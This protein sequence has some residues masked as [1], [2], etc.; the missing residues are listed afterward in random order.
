M[1]AVKQADRYL[2]ERKDRLFKLIFNYLQEERDVRPF[3]DLMQHMKQKHRMEDGLIVHATEWL[4]EKGIID[5]ASSP[6]KLT[7][8]SRVELDE[9]AYFMLDEEMLRG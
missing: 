6:V 9:V 4:A 8:K 1:D 2:Y 5:K 3:S 7:P